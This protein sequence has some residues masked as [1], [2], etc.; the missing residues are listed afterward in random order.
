MKQYQYYIIMACLFGI[1]S[2]VLTMEP[3]KT[4]AAIVSIV[5]AIISIFSQK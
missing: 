4:I 3:I 1:W 2:S 5:C